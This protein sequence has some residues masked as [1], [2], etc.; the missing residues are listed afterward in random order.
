MNHSNDS[1]VKNEE[2]SP[3][4]SVLDIVKSSVEYTL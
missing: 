2:K 4:L 3:L 1:I